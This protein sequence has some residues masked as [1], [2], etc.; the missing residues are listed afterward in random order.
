MKKQRF[1]NRFPKGAS[2]LS[3]IKG[4]IK[5]TRERKSFR[6]YSLALLS[7]VFLIV[8]Y[9][10]TH[11]VTQSPLSFTSS[12]KV[13]FN[14]D[15]RPILVQ[16]C[17]LCHGPDASSRKANLRLDT[18][19]GATATLK[20]GRKAVVP[21][22][23]DQS[24]LVSRILSDDPELVM[25][26]TES[27]LTLTEKEKQTLVKWIEEGAKYKQHWAFIPP[28]ATLNGDKTEDRID[29][30]INEK[31]ERQGLDP[32]PLATKNTLIRRVSYL[33][34]GLPP[35]PE[36]IQ[37]Y[38]TDSSPDAYEKM[39]DSYLS[40]KAY[41][42]RWARHWM[43]IV[44]YAETKGHE[45]DY[46][47]T[48]AWRYRDYLIRAFNNDVPYNQL[49]RE[50]LAGDLLKTGRIDPVTGANESPLGTAF[51][52]LGE[53][54]HSPVDIRKDEAD[55][56]D[57][58]VD[59]TT[60]AF[61]GLTV[62]CARCHDHKFDPISAADYYALYG[63]MESTRFSPVPAE[64]TTQKEKT[65][66]EL[67]QLK[68]YIRKSIADQWSLTQK[69][70]PTQPIPPIP[71]VSKQN[72]VQSDSIKLLGDFRNTDLYGWKSDGQA[73]GTKTTLG[74]P[75]FD[76]AG[77]EIIALEDGKA[78]SLTLGTGIFG[79]LRSPDF[80][81]DKNFIGV[82]AKGKNSSIRVIID[83]FQLISFPI[84]GEMDQRVTTDD[85]HN[86]QFNVGMWKGHKAYIEILPGLFEAHVYK[87]PADAFIEAKYAMAFNGQWVEPVMTAGKHPTTVSEALQNWA[88]G[89]STESEIALLNTLIR[90]KTFP[91]HLP[92]LN[93][94]LAQ[95]DQL[96]HSVADSTY[97][98]GVVDGFG[99]NSPIF[100][101][102][103]HQQLSKEKIPRRFLSALSG[104][105]KIFRSPGSGRLELAESIVSPENPLT[106]RIMVNRIWHYIFGKGIVETVDN[107][108]LQ[109]K[110]PTHPELLDYL[111]LQ[112]QKDGW[113]TRKMIR[114][115]LLSE[116][117]RRSVNAGN[118]VEKT[119]PDNLYLARFPRR[120]LEAE[121]IR[122]GL[123]AT[124]GNLNPVMYGPPVPIHI[125]QFMQGRGR[126]GQSGPLDGNGRRSVYQE[127]RRNFLDPMMLTFDRPTP[128]STFGRRNVT[129]VPAQ[130][131]ILMNDPFVISQSEKMAKNLMRYPKL[132]LDG[133]IQWIYIRAFARR[134]TP[135]EVA[136]AKGFIQNLAR[137][138]K[139]GNANVMKD[140]RIWK[141]YC[142][143]VFNLK[144]F[145]Y[146]I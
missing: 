110:L 11:S 120:R 43:D 25:P 16:K 42:E 98:N 50:H 20:K 133:R 8:V 105:N 29:D 12:E 113:S 39:I 88:E 57:N 19:E 74:N 95:R 90:K 14:F 80:V 124:A 119:D 103:S 115:I 144:E 33:L 112:Y 102:G 141:D 36:A 83:N 35:T 40:S 66:R 63:I 22:H 111:A 89:N 121:V 44:R 82:R 96:T 79:A 23:P 123:L 108:G 130:S 34:T 136:K 27:H 67:S 85:W 114:S 30:F 128:F 87:L 104:K 55:R 146:L 51:F 77:K 64:Q 70:K 53:G 9:N 4:M 69:S 24:E 116:T 45:F 81:I 28:K 49:V 140:L 97:F 72:N 109:G 37:K 54:T 132:T 99:I 7:G 94:L 138:H 145:I 76:P 46:T 73:F 52:T 122:D 13:D 91:K 125:T 143:S 31:L 118:D 126:P 75:V 3:F 60:K 38:T 5:Y 15:V 117:F 129:N 17:Y 41:G 48:G 59:V 127:V 32:A 56:I 131:L 101:R 78:S 139:T 92:Q 84:Y 134:A 135:E 86:F 65:I 100:I 58:M 137:M 142:H 61:Q 93:E 10:C 26:T 6:R 18:F 1:F 106:A 107:F 21:G 68:T 2:L 71:S 62:S 47:I